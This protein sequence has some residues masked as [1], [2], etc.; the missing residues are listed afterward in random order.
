[1][2][3]YLIE[4]VYDIKINLELLN[5]LVE[6]VIERYYA[7]YVVNKLVPVIEEREKGILVSIKND[8]D[9][10]CSI[11]KNPPVENNNLSPT[12][13]SLE[14]LINMEVNYHGIKWFLP[15]LTKTIGGAKRK[16]LGLVY[17]FVDTGKTSF[18]CASAA[19]FAKELKDTGE[20]IVYAG[21]E[22][23]G[24][25][26]S[27]RIN[28]A[29]LKRTKSEIA[30]DIGGSKK[31]LSELGRDKILVYDSITTIGQIEKLLDTIKPAILY[32]DQAPKIQI[33]RYSVH[34]ED[35]SG[36]QMLFNKYRELAKIYDT[37]II[38]VAQGVGEAE[39]KK[40][41]KLSDIYGSRVAIQGELDFAI[42]IG[43]TLDDL[44]QKDF[45][46]I[47]I[48]KNKMDDGDSHRFATNF[49]RHKCSFEEI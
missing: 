41:L 16:S 29:I 31:L 46:F 43:R 8:V 26:I 19:G 45:R 23:A 40:Y 48:P 14:E 18:V 28:Q 3:F 24:Y 37:C 30:N 47:N 10:Y 5:D 32:I 25:R 6:Q 2:F 7:A 49:I 15:S 38:G 27:F 12:N 33:G 13:F 39:S 21:N 11:L 9:K 4:E 34:E 1:M 20:K 35:V 36:L 17:A 42:G 22:E 44:A